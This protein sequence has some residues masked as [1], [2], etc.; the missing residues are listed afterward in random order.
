MTDKLKTDA[1]SDLSVSAGYVIP[2]AIYG[3]ETYQT[4]LEA[5]E[6]NKVM[7]VQKVGR[8]FVLCEECDR[9]YTLKISADQ[10]RAL[11]EEL[12]QLSLT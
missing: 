6:D 8:S 7:S 11:G 12:A 10:L 9:Y 5:I 2:D 3:E 4:M 1:A